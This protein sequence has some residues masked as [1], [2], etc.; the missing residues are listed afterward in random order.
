MQ[1][2]AKPRFRRRR[3][4]SNP[5]EQW[6]IIYL[7]GWLALLF[8]GTNYY[9]AESTLNAISAEILRLPV[10][11][12]NRTDI[13]VAVRQQTTMLNVQM[14]LF[15]LLSLVTL[16]LAGLILSHRIGGPIHQ[17]TSYLKALTAGMMPRAIRFRRHDFFHDLAESFNLFQ[18]SRGIL[19]P[20]DGKPS[21]KPSGTDAA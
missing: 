18:R 7:F 3:L 13:V 1:P 8:A 5:R 9:I 19:P 20:E 14:L 11:D 2:T 16:L 4:L 15:T 21:E 12:A 10:S 6:R 17:L